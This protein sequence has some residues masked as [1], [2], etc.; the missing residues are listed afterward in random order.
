MHPT[1]I[2][3]TGA[4][5]LLAASL[6]AAGAGAARAEIPGIAGSAFTLTARSDRITTPEG[7]SYLFWG[8]ASG[9]GRAQYPAP[10]L[11]LTSGQT[12]TVTL[13]N[14]LAPDGA[15]AVPNVSL[16]FPG[17]DNVKAFCATGSCVTGAL[18][19][20]AGPGGSVTYTFTASRPGTFAYYSGTR[21]D[22]QVEMG[23]TGAIVVR[24]AAFPASAYGDSTSA[25]DREYLFFL[26]EMDPR[27][28]DTVEQQGAAALAATDYLSDYFSNYWFI[29]G[30][31]APD[32]MN[33]TAS[34]FPTQP[35]DSMP[36]MHPGERLLMRVVG[37]GSQF[38]PFHHHGNH[39]RIIGRGG[40]PLEETAGQLDLSYE[41][42]TIQTG[43]GQAYDA[44]FEWTGKGLG[45]DM[46][47]TEGA[48]ASHLC[49]GQTGEWARAERLANPGNPYFTNY[50][51]TTR[52]WCG[53][54]G[55]VFPV[56]LPD[57][58]NLVNGGWWSGSPYMG[59]MGALPPGEGGLN[60]NAGYVFMWHS[61]TEKELTNFDVFPGGMM[62]MLIIEPVGVPIAAPAPA[63]NP[64]PGTAADGP[65]TR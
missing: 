30:R 9:G 37:G 7:G 60:P 64:P 5:L 46:Y 24:P 47:G 29:N 4:L 41:V 57:P 19:L 28:H 16:V 59:T 15:G 22:L 12:I 26:S 6:V 3:R 53:D 58:L 61:H 55:M 21:P 38:H 43:P 25:F 27:I 62:T 32:T 33:T 34:L 10:T 45:W 18:T 40:R 1:P 17:Q 56:T 13:T 14:A 20:E 52:E 63:P 8:L 2:H 49:N 23:L 48:A 42:F 51:P 36:R 54:H 11:I 31:A 44:L 65:A 39:A 35:Y 50:D